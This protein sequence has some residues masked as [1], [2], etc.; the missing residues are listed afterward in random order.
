MKTGERRVGP[1]SLRVRQCNALPP[2]LREAT[3]EIVNLETLFDKQGQGYAT[4]LMHKVCREAD[5]AGLTLVLTPQPYGDNI[6]LSAQQLE[7][8]YQREFGFYAVQ[9]DPMVFM[10]RLVNG[11]PKPMALKPVAEALYKDIK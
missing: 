11:T 3:R 9:R 6:N 10:A 8:W 4:T 2:H 1:A 7:E 5:A